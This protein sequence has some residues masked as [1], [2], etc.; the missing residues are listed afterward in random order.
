MDGAP[1]AWQGDGTY[2]ART[3]MIWRTGV[4]FRVG[5]PAQCI[6][7]I[8]PVAKIVTGRRICGP[9]G[10]FPGLV[11]LAYDYATD[12]FYVGDQ[13]G[14]ITHVDTAGTVLDSDADPRADLG[15]RV[16]PDDA[17]TS[18]SRRSP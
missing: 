4:A 8:D 9:W 11:G 10:N 3:G 2:N 12:T 17:A 18:T 6:F 7:E 16:Q 5:D 15:S 14:V 1:S 13:L